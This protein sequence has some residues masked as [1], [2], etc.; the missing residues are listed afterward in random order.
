[1]SDFNPYHQWL[2]ISE[3]ERP[4]SKYRLLSVDEFES[5]RDV[6]SAAAER[7]TIYLRTLQ[8]G[9]HAVLVAQLL[10]EVSQARVCLLDGK[11][12]SRYDT[13]LR[14]DLEP[15]PEQDPLAVAAEELAAISSRPATRPRSRSE[16]GK[17]FWQQ[18]WA[19][20][21]GGGGIVALLLLM[22]LFGSDG[23]DTKD[24]GN[25]STTTTLG[26]QQ[27][28]QPTASNETLP[29]KVV[30]APTLAVAPFDA[31]QAKAHQQ[32]W[33]KYLGVPVEY[34]NSIGMK[35][36][37]IPPGEFMMG[38]PETDTD[39]HDNEKP[40]VPVR[41]SRPF[42]LGKYEVTNWEFRQLFPEHQSAF[43]GSE[44]PVSMVNHVDCTMYCFRLRHRDMKQYRLPTEAEWEYA[45]RAGTTTRF[46]FGDS[47]QELNDHSW[48]ES[49]SGMK[50][51]T[52]GQKI[53]NAWGMFD[54]HG[55][56]WEMCHDGGRHNYVEL[57][58][59][60]RIQ[61]P[62]AYLGSE[63]PHKGGGFG[64]WPT[65]YL[66]SSMRG[67]A[68]MTELSRHNILGF[69]LLLE[70]PNTDSPTENPHTTDTK[71]LPASLQEGLVAYYPFNG[72][73]KDESGNGN[74]VTNPSVVFSSDRHGNLDNALASE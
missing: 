11:S 53:P 45:C 26:N 19:I 20:P 30:V 1:M 44:L 58:A 29:A 17:P 13:Q 5:D 43:D 61:D 31:A 9:E 49:N 28:T 55:N 60:E 39:A 70:I 38:A 8:A 4:I 51:H 46:S 36:M 35:F 23:T 32:F 6:I 37:L 63:R 2:G 12:K 50:A 71:S 16:G 18:P 65:T 3:T 34:T 47:M 40:Q 27:K 21:A 41:I 59:L 7:Q 62:I 57:S 15:A 66:R 56:V 74:H 64:R 69:R 73:A 10:N 72:N 67:K 48:N 14:S 25:K 52:V 42:Y 24:P 54:M 33:S 22:W 68:S